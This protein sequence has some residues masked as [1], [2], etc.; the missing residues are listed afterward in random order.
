MDKKIVV[1]MEQITKIFGSV[2]ALDQVDFELR[3]GEVHAL[4]GENGSGKSTLI[5]VL[6]GIHRMES[7]QIYLDGKPVSIED[8]FT[9]NK[10]GISIVHQE[11]SF[12]PRMTVADNI[13]MGKECR[14]RWGLIDAKR[15]CRSRKGSCRILV[16][17]LIQAN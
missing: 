8:V 6:G 1:R 7:G 12:A 13:F 17:I 5:K 9:A 4:L 11:L 14:N 10:L 3:A 2:K 15:S 16:L